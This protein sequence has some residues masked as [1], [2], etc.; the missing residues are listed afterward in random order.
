VLLGGILLL[1]ILPGIW[2]RSRSPANPGTERLAA[3][4]PA[5]GT[6]SATEPAA[7]IQPQPVTTR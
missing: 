6:P 2:G 7:G 4:D 5:Q 3:G 1:A